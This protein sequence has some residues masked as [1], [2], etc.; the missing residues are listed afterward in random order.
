M[1]ELFLG[2]RNF[3]IVCGVFCVWPI[4]V[5]CCWYLEMLCFYK[6]IFS[7]QTCR[8]LLLSL[9]VYEYCVIV[10]WEGCILD[11]GYHFLWVMTDFS[12]FII[13]TSLFHLLCVILLTTSLILFWIVVEAAIAGIFTLSFFK[14]KASNILSLSTIF[15]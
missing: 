8:T 6:L 15:D 5:V 7:L 10:F 9:I 14:G 3:V 1:L 2:V 12:S 4:L 11:L 13:H